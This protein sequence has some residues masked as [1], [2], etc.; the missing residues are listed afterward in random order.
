MTFD[1]FWGERLSQIDDSVFLFYALEPFDRYFLNHGAAS[2]YPPDRS[3]AV[4]PSLIY[5]GWTKASA[6]G[7]MADAIRLSAAKLVY[8]GERDGQNLKVAA[9]YV[10]YALFGTPLEKMYGG[11]LE[12]LRG[13]KKTYDPGAVMD[14]AGGWK[15]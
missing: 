10:N 14:L 9:P 4:F 1:K 7:S 11:N 3:H 15:I 13:I 6:D 12:R 5:L 8:A 2:A